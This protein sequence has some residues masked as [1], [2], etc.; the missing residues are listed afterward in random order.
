MNEFTRAQLDTIRVLAE[1]YF[2]RVLP[3]FP[4][5]AGPD[6]RDFHRDQYVKAITEGLTDP[7]YWGE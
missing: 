2:D 6:V 7:I 5:G 3:S 4:G 1:S